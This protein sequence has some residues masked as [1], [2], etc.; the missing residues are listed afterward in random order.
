M[1]ERLAHVGCL[2]K[3]DQ[4]DF[5]DHVDL[6]APQDNPVP[7]VWMD[8]KVQK[9]TWGLRGSRAQRG[10]RESQ[11]RKVSLA[12][13]VQSDLL[14]RRG[15]RVRLGCQAWREPMG[16]RDT[17]AKRDHLE[18]KVHRAHQVHKVQSAI[19]DREE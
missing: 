9:E 10:S 18:R 16:L 17:R 2:V 15:P 3:L 7:Q 12:H 5:L 6:Q 8:P 14:E 1:M 13:K 11:E 19:Q 4:G